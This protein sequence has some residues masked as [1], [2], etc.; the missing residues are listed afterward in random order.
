MSLKNQRELENTREKLRKL[1][2]GYGAIRA[3]TDGD[4]R[5]R[6]VEQGAFKRLIDQF[7]QEI[8]RYEANI[9][10]TPRIE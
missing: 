5:L 10:P 8:S 3:E 9:A 4:E 2:Q 7:K 1:P 6:Q